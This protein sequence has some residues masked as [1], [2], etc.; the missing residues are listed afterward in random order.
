MVARRERFRRFGILHDRMDAL[1]QKIGRE[2]VALEV[3]ALVGPQLAQHG[4][5]IAGGQR[6][7]ETLATFGIAAAAS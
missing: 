3:A 4:D 7:L 5:E 1:A 2:R 6:L